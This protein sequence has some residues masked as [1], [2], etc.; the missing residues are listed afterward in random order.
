[1]TTG[2]LAGSTIGVA[3]DR[4]AD[5]Q[6]TLL[7]GHGADCLRHRGTTGDDPVGVTGS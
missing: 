4:R 7:A 6:I 3:A 2:P 1:M 5:T